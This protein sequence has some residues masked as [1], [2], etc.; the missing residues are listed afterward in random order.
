MDISPRLLLMTLLMICGAQSMNFEH[1]RVRRQIKPLPTLPKFTIPVTTQKA[2]IAIPT[3]PNLKS[4]APTVLT[5]NTTLTSISS[6]G[7][8]NNVTNYNVT[9]AS[10]VSEPTLAVSSSKITIFTTSTSQKPT[11]TTKS[12]PTFKPFNPFLTQQPVSTTIAVASTTNTKRVISTT[13]FDID[14]FLA[15]EEK[16]ISDAANPFKDIPGLNLIP[17]ASDFLASNGGKMMSKVSDMAGSVLGNVDVGSLVSGAAGA[18]SSGG[19]ISSLVSGAAGALSGV[20]PSGIGSLVSGAGNM[21]S[22][23][24]ISD[25]FGSLLG[26][27]A[28]SK[29]PPS[30]EQKK[31][32]NNNNNTVSADEILNPASKNNVDISALISNAGDLLSPHLKALGGGGNANPFAGILGTF[33]AL[34]GGVK[35]S[36]AITEEP[37]E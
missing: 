25:M 9:A 8:E 35:P 29:S 32:S 15:K 4:K 1:S 12:Y 26:G 19:G 21:L 17:A 11:T 10:S 6:D 2:K 30:S 22:N 34:V 13:P 16:E 18:L 37:L 24:G 27:G 36:V 28:A 5:T 23:M 31:G 20:M 3:L 33:G 14:A 7:V